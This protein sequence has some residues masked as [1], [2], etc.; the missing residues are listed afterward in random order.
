MKGGCRASI[1]SCSLTRKS[2]SDRRRNHKTLD[3]CFARKQCEIQIAITLALLMFLGTWTESDHWKTHLSP[4]RRRWS[5]MFEG[6]GTVGKILS[7]PFQAWIRGRTSTK[8]D[9]G[10]LVTSSLLRTPMSTVTTNRTASRANLTFDTEQLK[11]VE[12][13]LSFRRQSGEE[14]K[15]ETWE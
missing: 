12:Q 9:G 5:W 11:S 6:E 13:H 14:E 1:L 4:N 8:D 2:P 15:E 7:S 10:M 3:S